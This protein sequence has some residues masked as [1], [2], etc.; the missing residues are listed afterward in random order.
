MIDAYGCIPEQT[1]NFMLVNDFLINTV[2]KLEMAP[3]M[4]PYVLP[5]Y[6]SEDAEDVGI[7]AF[8][9]C[10]EG[11]HVTIHTFPQRSCYFVDI[12]TN[13]FLSEEEVADFVKKQ[14]YASNLSIHTVDRRDFDSDET[15]VDS[16]NDFG[17]HYMASVKSPQV[18]FEGIYRWL[19]TI[20]PE[21]NMQPISRP[22]VI[23]NRVNDPSYISGV[24]VVAQSHI[25]FHYSIEDDVANVDI[26]SCSFLGNGVV[27][28]LLNACFGD[29]VRLKLF[30]RGSKHR[31]ECQ[32]YTRQSR[33]DKC[34]AWR[35]NIYEI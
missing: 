33:I 23:Y 3:I 13:S 12:L 17:P 4:P 19:D 5:F 21:I 30:A 11:S 7:S 24:L 32:H 10:D 28:A 20:A 22:Y 15:A 25:A 26:F 34:K 18:D 9:I 8:T 2:S 14:L 16:Q 35:N 6:Y 1:N 31:F 27:E 29:K